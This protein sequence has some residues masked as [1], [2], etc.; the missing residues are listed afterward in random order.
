MTFSTLFVFNENFI[1]AIFAE[2][3]NF[4]FFQ[5]LKKRGFQVEAPPDEN[6][7]LIGV[8][9]QKCYPV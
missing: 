2:M 9:C 6:A 8:A 3:K 5:F 4:G 1:F 7:P